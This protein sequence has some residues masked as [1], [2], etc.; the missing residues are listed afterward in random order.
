MKKSGML[1]IPKQ[2][3]ADIIQHAFEQDPN[4]CCG[5]LFGKEGRVRQAKRIRNVSQDRTRYIMDAAEQKSATL[6]AQ[7][8]SGH[9]P[10]AFYHSHPATAAYPSGV[11]IQDAVSTGWTEP[12]YVIVSLAEKTRPVIRAFAITLAGECRECVIE[13]E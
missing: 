11:D 12:Y 1:R 8:S 7:D 5:I 3:A 10:V 13:V 6:E 2:I 4:E 9:E